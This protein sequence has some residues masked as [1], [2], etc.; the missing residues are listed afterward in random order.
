MNRRKSIKA[1]F[2]GTVSTGVLIEAC[3]APDKKAEEAKAAVQPAPAQADRM[4][5]EVEYNK[6]LASGKFFNAHELA[7][8]G[9]L[10]DI[11]I[12]SD[13]KS[14]SA[15]DAKVPDFIE[16]MMLDRPDNQTPMRGG[17]R[18]L[19]M[20]CLKQYEKTFID[21][22]KEQQLEMVN[23]IAYPKKAKPEYQQGSNFFTLIRNFTVTGFYTTE[24]G[25]KDLGYMG[26]KPHQWNG[27]PTD[28][29]K[30]YNVAYSEKEL[31]ECV[32][33]DKA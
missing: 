2:V 15:T 7:T 33:Y 27:V 21:C 8:V 20:A 9:V 3:D 30:Q 24:I 14:G 31:K 26:N 25:F 6:E 22:S 12:P 17:L 11:I 1:L 16:F 13:E 18:W 29:L 19:D 10:A 28:V 4:K 32:S 5:E 23:L